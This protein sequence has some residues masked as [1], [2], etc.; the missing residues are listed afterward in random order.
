MPVHSIAQQAVSQPDAAQAAEA[1]F[2]AMLPLLNKMTKAMVSS[3]LQV[4][5]EPQTA[6]RIAAFKKNL[7][8]ALLKQGFNKDQA[9][10]ITVNTPLPLIAPAQGKQ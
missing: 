1:Q 6:S 10:V 7:Y 9:L 3:E 2:D 5:E 8:E 4:A